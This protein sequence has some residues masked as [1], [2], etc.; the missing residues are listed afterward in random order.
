MKQKRDKNYIYLNELD[1]ELE[2]RG[3]HFA[4]YA[5]D[6]VIFVKTEYLSERVMRNIVTF[7]ERKLKL[8]VNADKTHIT[9]PN[10]LKYLGFTFWKSKEGWLSKPH[11]ESFKKLFESVKI[12]STSLVNLFCTTT[13]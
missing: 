10:N 4:R 5:D 2:R 11:Q 7:I 9:R 13:Q 6:C 12:K 1:K 8:K 3:L